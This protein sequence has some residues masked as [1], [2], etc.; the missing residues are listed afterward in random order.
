M[1]YFFGG[2][3]FSIGKRSYPVINMNNRIVDCFADLA[4]DGCPVERARAQT[5]VW[6]VSNGIN[7]YLI[8]RECEAAK[9]SFLINAG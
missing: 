5:K 1:L 9:G 7:S 8:S 4:G 6:L 2:I 3:E